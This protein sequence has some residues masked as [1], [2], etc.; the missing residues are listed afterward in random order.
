MVGVVI[1]FPLPHFIASRS[2]WQ[3][4]FNVLGAAAFFLRERV[5]AAAVSM[6][7]CPSTS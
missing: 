5:F 2:N 7:R 1:G 3:V 6:S 4:T